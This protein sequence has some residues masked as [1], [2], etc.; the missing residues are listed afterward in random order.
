MATLQTQKRMT[1]NA[2]HVSFAGATP[3]SA[4]RHLAL[5]CPTPVGNAACNADPKIAGLQEGNI[6]MRQNFGLG[7]CACCPPRVSM[8]RRGL[9]G[10]LAATTLATPAL[11]QSSRFRIDVHH[12]VCPPAWIAALK[13]AKLDSPPVNNW[14]PEHSLADMDR[15]GIKTAILSVTQP[16][17]GFLDSKRAAEVARACN[18]YS[19]EL[20]HRYPGRFGLFAAL[21]LPHV[22][23]SLAELAYALDVLKADGIGMLTSYGRTFLG[24]AVFA[25]IMD[26]LNRRRVTVYTHPATP[27]CCVNLAGLPDTAVE[28][29]TDTTRTIGN[30]IFSGTAARTPDINWIFSHAGGTVWSVTE[31]F[32]VQMLQMPQFKA[33][34]PDAVFGQLKRFYYDTAQAANPVAM[35]GLTKVVAPSQILF[36]TDYPYRTAAEQVASLA[37][38]FSGETLRQ[39]EREN[40]RRLLKI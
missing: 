25:P 33:F 28:Y 13:D 3:E 8:G 12:H 30:L 6:A 34:T 5:A 19:H 11:A 31:R 17:M 37:E 32:T 7:G 4:E 26:E 15:G 20:T 40:A 36:G 22:P 27:A 21:P 1:G 29:G 16:G 38:V 14:T 39:I 23:E 2:D 10:G 18:E 35:A 24:D 9:L